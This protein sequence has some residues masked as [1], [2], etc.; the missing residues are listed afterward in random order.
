MMFILAQSMV[1][2]EDEW[3]LELQSWPQGW[4]GPAFFTFLLFILIAV[5]W[6]YQRERRFGA[7][8][9]VRRF[10]A[11]LRSL[12]LLILLFILLGPAMT[13]YLHRWM[14]AYT[15]VLIDT[16]ASMS[17]TDEAAS[18]S[19]ADDGARGS[20]E[21]GVARSDSASDGA[22]P[23]GATRLGRVRDFLLRD[24]GEFLRALTRSNRVRLI[25]F[26]RNARSL[27]ALPYAGE[28]AG[29]ASR[30]DG[31]D[32]AAFF[33]RLPDVLPGRA[34]GPV[35]NIVGSLREAVEETGASPIAGIVVFSDGAFNEGGRPEGL[36]R[37][38]EDRGLSVHAVGVG[39]PGPVLNARLAGI[40]APDRVLPG[41]PFEIEVK[42]TAEGWTGRDVNLMLKET[43]EKGGT[44]K[45]LAQRRIIAGA[46]GAR[47]NVIFTH[48]PEREGV[49]RYEVIAEKLP[50][51]VLFTDNRITAHVEVSSKQSRVLLVAGHPS[52]EYH[53]LE[54]LLMRD[55]GIELSCWLQ[56]AD[57]SAV[58][59]GDVILRRMPREPREL[60]EYDVIILLDPDPEEMD[61]AWCERVDRFVTEL[62]GG[63]A[64]SAGRP[65]SHEFL[66][67]P[68]L[69]RL[70]DLFPVV[71]DPDADLTLNRLGHFQTRPIG[72]RVDPAARAHPILRHSFSETDGSLDWERLTQVYWFLPILR[73]KPA[74]T[75]LWRADDAT[76]SQARGG[77]VLNAVQYVG[78]GLSSFCAFDGTWRWQRGSDTAFDEYWV[79]L[80]RYLSQGKKLAGSERAR[81]VTDAPAYEIGATAIIRAQLFDE[82]YQPRRVERVEALITLEG[83]S[84][85]LELLPKPDQPGWYEAL[86]IADRAGTGEVRLTQNDGAAAGASLAVPMAVTLPDAEMARTRM[87]EEAL[88]AL[89]NA[90]TSG[91]YVTLAEANEIPPLIPDR[92][93]VATTRGSSLPLW[94][95]WWTLALV[96]LLLSLE[97]G[98]RRWHHLL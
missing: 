59:D 79:R 52:W 38:L 44:G 54:R 68:E 92:H 95:R 90:S 43:D 51:E 11:G 64:Y 47:E 89:A 32:A 61:A 40:S 72:I 7:T 16:S 45:L 15:L 53:F 1:R 56:S 69:S 83:E 67:R 41:D 48:T 60:F 35:S 12:V 82:D 74:A 78:A 58:R 70:C 28:Q 73:E 29:A 18:D 46:D 97:W 30:E 37:F 84:S 9:A 27:G 4:K 2:L 13:R 76:L 17:L 86:W 55:R 81:L 25:G 80:V 3:R 57:G 24:N 98:L 63:L 75:V 65:F 39:R 33:A 34:G 50:G 62:G 49:F 23:A 85:G 88:R 10:L 66:R 96:T 42:V 36:T 5:F 26:D 91:R 87:D 20:D 22:A 14:D 19:P 21:G 31:A 6:A 77:L 94:D 8:A 93:E 71:V